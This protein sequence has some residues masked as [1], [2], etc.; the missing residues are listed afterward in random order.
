MLA[1]KHHL[2]EGALAQ[3]PQQGM[4]MP[5]DPSFPLPFAWVPGTFQ[6]GLVTA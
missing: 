4:E 6:P 5:V 2:L 1:L 3:A